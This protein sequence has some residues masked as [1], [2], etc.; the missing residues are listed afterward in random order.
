MA[1]LIDVYPIVFIDAV[2]EEN[3]VVKKAAYIVLGINKDGY[4][5]I[6]GIWIGENESSKFWL[7]VLND[8]KQR[9]V[10]D[11]LIMCSD[12]LTGIKQAIEAVYPKTIQQRCIVHMIRNSVKF[13]SYKDLKEFCNDLKKIYTAKNE[14]QGYEELQKVKEKWKDKY[15]GTFRTWEENWDA[16]CPFFQFSEPI[17]KIM[18]T[19]NTI[20]SLNRQFRKYTKTKS[21]FSTDMS[22]L[23]CL[24]YQQKILLKNGLHLI[25]IGGQYYQN[26]Q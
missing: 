18:Y 5:E 14:K 8:L 10:T 15:I 23:K 20:E 25:K 19:T 21:V 17:R 13:V 16:I 12:N 7:G 2:Q 1:R 6:L 26:C 3:R 22:L 24:Y 4:K 11:I 9:G